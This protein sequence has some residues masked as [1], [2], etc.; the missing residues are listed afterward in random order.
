MEAAYDEIL[1]GM[2]FSGA[3][4]PRTIAVLSPSQGDGKSTTAAN[5]ALAL[6]DRHGP[7]LLVD[8]DLRRPTLHRLMRVAESP[9]VGDVIDR[10]FTLEQS[11]Q[12]SGHPQIDVLAAGTRVRD[13]VSTLES[14]RL[15]RLLA[16]AGQKYAS[17]VVDTSALGPVHD[18]LEVARAVDGSLLVLSAGRTRVKQLARALERLARAQTPS[19]VGYVLNRAKTPNE[20]YAYYAKAEER[21]GAA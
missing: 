19:L 20:R 18:A 17:I 4:P 2:R 16:T 6:A 21:Y 3:R 1:D 7:V 12:R 15:R 10:G 8:G 5:L 11:I 13:P 9:G 14:G